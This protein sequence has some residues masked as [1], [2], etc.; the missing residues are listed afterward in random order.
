MYAKHRSVNSSSCYATPLNY[1]SKLTVPIINPTPSTIIPEIFNEIKPNS[2]IPLRFK[3]NINISN[4]LS[5]PSQYKI[6]ENK[7]N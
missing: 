5:F 2:N 6:F 1:G 3:Q 4:T 7:K